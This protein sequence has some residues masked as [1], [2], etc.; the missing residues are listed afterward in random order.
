MSCWSRSPR[1]IER[2]GCGVTL[3]QTY[4]LAEAAEAHRAIESKRTTGKIV[5]VP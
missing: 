1:R 3:Q 2:A 5:L 4:P